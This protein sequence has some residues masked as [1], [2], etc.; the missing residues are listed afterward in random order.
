MIRVNQTLLV[1]TSSAD[2]Y[3]DVVL[4]GNTTPGEPLSYRVRRGDTLYGIGRRHSTTAQSIAAASGISVNKTLSIGERLVV[5]PGA[6]SSN[7]ARRIATGG[8]IQLDG[9]S[10]RV[11]TV[12]RG[13]TLWQIASLYKTSVN[14]LCSLNDIS[15]SATLYPG[16]KLTVGHN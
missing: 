3:S 2:R 4:A 11:H 5:V 16:A 7:E 8:T 10:R 15:R 13:D 1:P 14:V 6:R 9:S 12:R